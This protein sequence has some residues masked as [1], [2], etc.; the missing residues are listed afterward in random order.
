MLKKNLF[1]LKP[2]LKTTITEVNVE[3]NDQIK[4]AKN[5]NR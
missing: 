2:S 4:E 1:D 5:Y 3:K